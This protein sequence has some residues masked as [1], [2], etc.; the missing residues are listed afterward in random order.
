[1][2]VIWEIDVDE[3]DPRQAA[4]QALEIMRDPESIATVFTTIDDHGAFTTVDL[5]KAATS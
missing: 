4:V 5:L 2:R 1:M 3:Q